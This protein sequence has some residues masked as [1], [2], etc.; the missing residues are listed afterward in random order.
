MADINQDKLK[1]IL[2]DK[3]VFKRGETEIVYLISL[4]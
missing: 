4:L 1:E 3:N 2:R